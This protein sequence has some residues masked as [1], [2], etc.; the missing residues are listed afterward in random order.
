M[1]S[2]LQRGNFLA[3]AMSQ[4]VTLT[5]GM[6][7]TVDIIFKFGTQVSGTFMN[8]SDVMLDFLR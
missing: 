6:W 3:N 2:L 8:H 1:I 7:G 5:A 4:N